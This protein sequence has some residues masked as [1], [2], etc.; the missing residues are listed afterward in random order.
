MAASPNL[1]HTLQTADNKLQMSSA[2]SLCIH[3]QNDDT[4]SPDPASS[5][6]VTTTEDVRSTRQVT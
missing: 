2:N 4:D 5:D 6:T 1:H 3:T